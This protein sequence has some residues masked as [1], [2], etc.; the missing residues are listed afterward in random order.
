[1]IGRI[2]FRSESKFSV[3]FFLAFYAIDEN[4]KMGSIFKQLS[5]VQKKRYYIKFLKF[6][7]TI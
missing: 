6:V 1:M 3:V 7:P 4:P 2:Y 5:S